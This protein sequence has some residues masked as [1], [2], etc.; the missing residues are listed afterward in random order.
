[1]V[2]SSLIGGTAQMRKII[3]FVVAGLILAATSNAVAQTAPCRPWCVHYAAPDG[4][5]TNCGFI[6]YEQCMWTAQGAD[7]CMPN[8]ACP[9]GTRGGYDNSGRAPGQRR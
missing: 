9:P 7:K 1:M 3:L 5:G 6:S 8:G 4:G 2:G